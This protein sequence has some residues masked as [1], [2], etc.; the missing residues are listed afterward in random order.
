MLGAAVATAGALFMLA[1]IRTF[2]TQK[3]LR[4]SVPWVRLVIVSMLVVMGLG[5]SAL[6]KG[7]PWPAL[8]GLFLLMVLNRRELRS[9]ARVVVP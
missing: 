1:V 6:V 9:I 3:Y 7:W 4:I 5:G 8:V 2:H